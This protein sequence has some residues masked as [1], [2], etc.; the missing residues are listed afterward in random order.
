MATSFDE[1][2]LSRKERAEL[3]AGRG[4]PKQLWRLLE[5][6]LI[7]TF[8]QQR[9][10]FHQSCQ[11]AASQIPDERERREVRA[12]GLNVLYGLIRLPGEP[13]QDR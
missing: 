2:G 8:T 10:L 12:R 11:V 13:P 5:E 6:G 7:L 9:E 1:Q 3:Y 4:L